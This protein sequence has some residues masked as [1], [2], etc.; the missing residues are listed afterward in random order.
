MTHAHAPT[1]STEPALALGKRLDEIGWALFLILTGVVWLFPETRVPP[2]T[3]LIATGVLLLGLNAIRAISRVTVSGFT[4]ILGALA[5][6]AGLTA[7]WGVHLPLVAICLI[8]LGSGLLARQLVGR[9]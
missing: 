4:T 6:A 9:A 3:W 8:L 1:A 2:G 7:L 5:L